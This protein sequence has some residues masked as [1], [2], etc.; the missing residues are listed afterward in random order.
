VRVAQSP[1]AL[2]RAVLEREA[3][4][5]ADHLQARRSEAVGAVGARS[6]AWRPIFM[7]SSRHPIRQFHSYSLGRQAE[8]LRIM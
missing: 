7:W 6:P 4:L 2:Q 8:R 3:Q 5:E 1:E